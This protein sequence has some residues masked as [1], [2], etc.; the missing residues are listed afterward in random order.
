[1]RPRDVLQEYR[2]FIIVM[3]AVTQSIREGLP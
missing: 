2:L 1:M 3:K